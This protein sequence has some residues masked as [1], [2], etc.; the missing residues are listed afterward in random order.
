M[1]HASAA[2]VLGYFFLMSAAE[3]GYQLEGQEIDQQLQRLQASKYSFLMY[4]EPATGLGPFFR[5]Y[6]QNNLEV[7]AALLRLFQF[8]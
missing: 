5:A 2:V 1:Q 4:K 6:A 8:A 3:L 7:F